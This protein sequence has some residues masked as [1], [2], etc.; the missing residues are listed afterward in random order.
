MSFDPSSFLN[1]TT[2]E[3]NDTKII[4]CPA[5]EYLAL[6][7][8]VDIKT[9]QKKDGSASGLKLEILW[10]IQDDSVR[11]FLDRD[12]VTV[13]QDQMLDVLE[14]GN[15]DNPYMLDQGKGKNVGLGRIREALG[16]N[17]PGEPF[18]FSM[19]G[20]RLAKVKVGHR[21]G[22]TPEDVFAEV[23]GIASAN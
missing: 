19:I 13:R 12:K 20:G 17:A 16:L 18:S 4:P 8:K 21:T 1:Q 22:N 15:P 10:E 11:Q 9:W 3:A 2:T 5:G 23:N 7:D 6:A 14:T